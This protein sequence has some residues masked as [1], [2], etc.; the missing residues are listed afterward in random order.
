MVPMKASG[1]HEPSSAT[2]RHAGSPP[3]PSSRQYSRVSGSPAG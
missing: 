2:G 1:N 3:P